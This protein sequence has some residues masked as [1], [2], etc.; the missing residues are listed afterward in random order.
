MS[1]DRAIV[2]R[3]RE[4][5]RLLTSHTPPRPSGESG[6]ATFASY[7]SAFFNA[8]TPAENRI[9]NTSPTGSPTTASSS[10]ASS[11]ESSK[12]ASVVGS[13][14]RGGAGNYRYATY[15][16]GPQDVI[17]PTL[18]RDSA[19]SSIPAPAAPSRAH[20]R[21]DTSHAGYAASYGYAYDPEMPAASGS[22]ST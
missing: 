2:S 13:G 18:S 7:A 17:S 14:G 4:S 3:Q 16:S 8:L 11:I 10:S 1:F 15:K 12:R 20:T 5:I 9:E 21:G 19:V 22:G 6:F